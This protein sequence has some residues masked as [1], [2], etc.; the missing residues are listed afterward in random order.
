MPTSIT[1]ALPLGLVEE[2]RCRSHPLWSFIWQEPGDGPFLLWPVEGF[3][4]GETDPMS[5]ALE[6]PLKHGCANR[7]K[8]PKAVVSYFNGFI[9]HQN[10]SATLLLASLIVF[11]C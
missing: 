7:L 10:N 4:S 2:I 5:Y 6:N 8:G 9:A 1:S 11:N 3:P